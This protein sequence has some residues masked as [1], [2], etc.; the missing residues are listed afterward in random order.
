MNPHELSIHD[1]DF[2]DK[3]YVAGSVRRTSNYSHFGKGIDF[4]GLT[5][6]PPAF[7]QVIDNEKNKRGDA[8]TLS[9][10]SLPDHG[11]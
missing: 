4:D 10:V 7:A 5:L 6:P 8:N 3:L 9:R 2:Y 1:P 11:P